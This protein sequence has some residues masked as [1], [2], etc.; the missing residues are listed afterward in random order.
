MAESPANRDLV[1]VSSK[2]KDVRPSV[3]TSGTVSWQEAG[4]TDGEVPT[5]KKKTNK[6]EWN[7]RIDRYLIHSTI[8]RV[9]TAYIY[10][11]LSYGNKNS[12]LK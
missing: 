4:D 8:S 2:G 11:A 10:K 1:I 12:V 5:K 6:K 7:N 3:R 9:S